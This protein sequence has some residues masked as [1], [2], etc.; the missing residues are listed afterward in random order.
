MS[1][2]S[3]GVG[4]VAAAIA[5]LAFL[6]GGAT[7]QGRAQG[8]QPR[9]KAS[10]SDLCFPCHAE[11]KQKFAQPNV[12]TPVK[13]GMC[14]SC[15]NPHAARFPKLLAKKGAD[16]CFSCHARA[17]V[18]FAK[19]TVHAP[20]KDGNCGAC[21]DPHASKEKF[22]LAKSGADLCLGCHTKLA[23]PRKVSH[24]PFA[25]GDCL[26]CH[27][28]HA[29][30]QHALL[31]KTSAQL[32]QNCHDLREPKVRRAHGNFRID[33]ARCEQCHDPHSSDGK[34]LAKAVTHPP[35]AQGRCG[36]CHDT[37]SP[38]PL[39]TVLAGKDLC[40]V[41]HAAVSQDLKKKVVHK[42]V[43]GGQC[44]SCHQPHASNDKGLLVDDE[45]QVCLGCH[46]KVEER[47]RASRSFHPAKG[48]A[49]RCTSCH[50]PHASDEPNMFAGDSLK[51][52][53]GC[54]G[55]HST[56]SHPMGPGTIDPR[57]QKTLN[58]LSCHDPH[59]TAQPV[60]LTAGKERALCIQCHKALR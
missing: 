31:V 3:P 9:T 59:G 34:A 8:Q 24:A 55:R 20:V 33:Q 10:G 6:A 51:V 36:N 40:M 18:V 52:C 17:K 27:D 5:V 15:H 23:T 19:K 44:T 58:C 22:Q 32:C 38:D 30:D 46:Q 43:A 1:A 11:L 21:H 41:C 49:Q 7:S 47:F 13:M 42:P 14:E 60:F 37:S 50:A 35:F 48:P 25:A 54:H 2:R 53:S 57:T 29:T 12:H 4:I 56:L 28:P 16:L 45:R 26:G 39:K